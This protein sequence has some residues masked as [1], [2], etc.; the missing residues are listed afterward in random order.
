MLFMS[1]LAKRNR[2]EDEL[3]RP[4]H[5]NPVKPRDYMMGPF[6]KSVFAID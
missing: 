5:D 6:S 3:K 2:E 1:L 4:R